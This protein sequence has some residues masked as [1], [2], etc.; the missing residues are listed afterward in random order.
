MTVEHA[1]GIA[2]RSRGVAK[3]SRGVLVEVRPVVE[4][5]VSPGQKLF[6][7]QSPDRQGIRRG[8]RHMRPVCHDDDVGQAFGPAERR[9][10]LR[11]KGEVDE[12]KRICGVVQD[13]RD[14]VGMQARIDRMADSTDAGDGVEDFQVP[15]RAAR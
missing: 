5:T 8:F 15:V 4:L 3:P 2:R 12:H 10:G 11:E 13:P 1:L 9:F 6:V 7:A 14:L